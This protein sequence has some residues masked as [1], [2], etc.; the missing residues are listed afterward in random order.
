MN[1]VSDDMWSFLRIVEEST[2]CCVVQTTSDRVQERVE[3]GRIR[4]AL[5]RERSDIVG[6]EEAELDA[7]DGRRGGQMRVHVGGGFKAQSHQLL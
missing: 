3:G 4:Y 5:H 7:L 2:Q 1:Y 6:G